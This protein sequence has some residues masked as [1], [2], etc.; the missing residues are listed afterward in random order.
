MSEVTRVD[1][2]VFSFVG[3]V[4]AWLA[5]VMLAKIMLDPHASWSQRGD[6]IAYAN[7][8]KS[9]SAWHEKAIVSMSKKWLHHMRCPEFVQNAITKEIRL[10]GREKW[11]AGSLH[12]RLLIEATLEM[13]KMLGKSGG[14]GVETRKRVNLW[15]GMIKSTVES[16][17]IHSAGE[18]VRRKLEKLASEFVVSSYPCGSNEYWFFDAGLLFAIIPQYVRRFSTCD[19]KCIDGWVFT[20][21][22]SDGENVNAGD[23][24][25]NVTE[26]GKKYVFDMNETELSNWEKGSGCLLYEVLKMKDHGLHNAEVNVRDVE[27]TTFLHAPY[28]SLHQISGAAPD[29]G[30]LHNMVMTVFQNNVSSRALGRTLYTTQWEQEQLECWREV[31]TEALRVNRDRVDGATSN[32]EKY[33]RS[34]VKNHGFRFNISPGR[35]YTEYTPRHPKKFE[36]DFFVVGKKSL[37]YRIVTKRSG[38]KR[39]GARKKRKRE[40]EDFSPFFSYPPIRG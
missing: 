21:V 5:T 2:S 27:V 26:W 7:L 15:M 3:G 40:F 9:I 25:N 18:D 37:Y 17:L 10:G 29:V 24:E 22:N 14:V 38:T 35:Q 20:D 32:A 13:K 12:I 30:Y 16:D 4:E 6:K 28:V 33:R 31:M 19:G 39:P 36:R 34:Y 1:G 23:D 8:L 11:N